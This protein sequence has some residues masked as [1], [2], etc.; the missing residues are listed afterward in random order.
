M[1]TM[2]ATAT[3]RVMIGDDADRMPN[4]TRTLNL[5]ERAPAMVLPSAFRWKDQLLKINDGNAAMNLKP[6]SASNLS[7]IRKESFS[8]YAP[9]GRGDSFACCGTCDEYKQL[10]SA[11]TPMSIQREKWEKVLENHLAGQKA[12]RELY[13]AHRY[14]SEEYPKK[15]VTIIHDKMDHSKIASLHFSHKSK[16]TE[17]FMKLPV[18]ITR[19]IVHGHGD[20]RYAHYGLDIYPMNP[21]HT[22]GSIAKL[23]RD[24]EGCKEMRQDVRLQ[25]RVSNRH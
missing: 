13:Y 7:R 21:N 24:L 18:A 12:H 10:R 11:C 20:V 23:L 1:H 22:I 5:G 16:A 25:R 9:K 19:M 3:L 17:S 15:M 6:I 14:I 8:E 4:K 2:Q